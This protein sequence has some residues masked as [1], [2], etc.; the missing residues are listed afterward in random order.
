MTPYLMTYIIMMIIYRVLEITVMKGI[1]SRLMGN[2]SK[3]PTYLLVVIPFILAII[4]PPLEYVLINHQPAPTSFFSGLG[5]FIV[6]TLFRIKGLTDLKGGFSPYIEKQ[7]NNTLIT[8][9]VYSLV[10]HPLYLSMLLLVIGAAIMLSAVWAWVFIVAVAG[11]VLIRIREEEKFLLE[12]F[13]E[14]RAYCKKTWRLVPGI[15]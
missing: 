11:G 2:R 4:T 6:A 12:Q 3:D 7:E 5:L 15:Y 13:P 14:Y 8:N 1:K 10:R 9:G